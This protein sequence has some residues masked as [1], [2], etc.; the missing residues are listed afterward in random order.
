[1]GKISF[2]FYLRNHKTT[3]TT[4]VLRQKGQQRA[5]LCDGEDGRGR[6]MESEADVQ[7]NMT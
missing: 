5:A 3:E 4:A 7:R 2:N 1:M 6:A